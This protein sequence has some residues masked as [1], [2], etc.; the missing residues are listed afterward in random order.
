METN[1]DKFMRRK[2]S[3]DPPI[4]T[5]HQPEPE[6]ETQKNRCFITLPYVHR[7]ADEFAYRLKTKVK[8]CY[9]DLDFNV[10]FNH[11][12]MPATISNCR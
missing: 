5:E 10:A 1:I 4:D 6:I 12:I 2:N 11:S 9:P 8:K 3:P 7:K